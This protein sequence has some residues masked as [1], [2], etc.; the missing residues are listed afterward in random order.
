MEFYMKKNQVLLPK[1]KVMEMTSFSAS[2]L[3]RRMQDGSFPKSIKIGPNRVAW[4]LSDV[5]EWMQSK[6]CKGSK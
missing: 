4:K 3:W 5:E 1:K 6:A 2:S